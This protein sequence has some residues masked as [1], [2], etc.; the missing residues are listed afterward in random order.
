MSAYNSINGSTADQQTHLLTDILKGEWSFAGFVESDWV[1]GTHGDAAS[2]LAGLDIEMPSGAHFGR[3]RTAVE[4]GEIGAD[5]IAGSVRRI[6]RAQLCHGL[7]EETVV[8]DDPTMRETADHL[9][10]ARQVARRGLVLLRNEGEVLPFTG[11]DSIVVAGRNADVENIGDTGSSAVT[12]S[13]VVTALEG[14]TERAGPGVTVTH[15]PGTTIGPEEQAILAAADVVVV[16]T[17]LQAADE[18]ESGVGAGD[19]AD[20]AV[21]AE[22]VALIHAIAAVHPAVVVVLEGGS[23]FVTS[24]WDG[25]VEGLVHAFYPGSEGGR[26]LADVLFGDAAPSGRLPFSMPEAEA[27]LPAFDNVSPTVTYDYFHGYRHLRNEGTPARYPFGF[28]LSYTTF[29]HSGL[30]L[31][32]DRVAPDGVLTARVTVT[33]TGPVAATDTVQLYVRAVGSRVMR[34]PTDLRGFAQVGLEPGAS[35]DVDIPVRAADLAFY[36]VD[37]SAWEVEPIAYEVRIAAD[38][39]D[40]GRVATFQVAP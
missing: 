11:V 22:E 15:L 17:G 28:G 35:A 16:V 32:R 29:A 18:G 40:P 2:V 3:L 31:D 27:D 5:A 30:T 24:D 7:D 4:G 21:P 26:A 20:L 14:I 34:S 13:A 8:R 37:A 9:A 38:A 19:R 39:D 10:L 6:L 1:L 23:A 12:P 33:N 36:D 25:E